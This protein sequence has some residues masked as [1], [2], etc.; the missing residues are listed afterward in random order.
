MVDMDVVKQ[1]LLRGAYTGVGAVVSG[2]IGNVLSNQINNEMAVAVG[3]IAVGAGVS[4]GADEVFSERE[5]IPNEFLEFAG[6]GVQAVGWDELA[7]SANLG[8][9]TDTTQTGAEVINVRSNASQAEEDT[10]NESS[11]TGK[12]LALD[13]A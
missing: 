2:S 12:T 4:V 8:A 7:E 5:S 9:M 13:T 11:G 3:E 6:Y 10:T 1:R